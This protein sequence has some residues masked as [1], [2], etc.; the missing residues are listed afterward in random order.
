MWAN[1]YSAEDIGRHIAALRR[2]RGMTQTEFAEELGI[3]RATLSSLEN[4]GSVSAQLLVRALNRLG[5]RLIIAPKSATV[6]VNET[7]E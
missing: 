3:A 7:L 4:G 1:A 5:S 6:A 2:D